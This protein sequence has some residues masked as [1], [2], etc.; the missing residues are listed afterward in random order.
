[1]ISSEFDSDDTIQI[2]I[3][4]ASVVK[5]G[6]RKSSGGEHETLVTSASVGRDARLR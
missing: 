5:R 4:T 6:R 1:M 2:V 3:V